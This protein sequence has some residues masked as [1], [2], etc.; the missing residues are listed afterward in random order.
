M[1]RTC[2]VEHRFCGLYNTSHP[3]PS[4]CPLNPIVMSASAF[5]LILGGAIAGA[6]VRSKLPEHHLT[7][8]SKEVIRLSTALV[9]TLTALV[10]ALMF[11]ATRAS[12]EH[13]AASI[14]RLATDISELDDVLEEYGP[15][16]VPI[17]K[18]LREEMGPLIDAMWR[19]DAIAA[20]RVAPGRAKHNSTALA[21]VR[22]LQPRT[23][24]QASL[25]ARALQIS[26]DI[27]QTRLGLFAQPPDSVSTPFM[28]VLILWMMFLFTT[29]SMSAK[30]NPT[31]AIVLFVCILSASGAIYLI[32]ELGLP[33]DGLMQVS[34]ES[35]RE[36]LAPI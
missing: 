27:Q 23:P 7:G 30:P 12:F 4:R 6:V 24:G 16:A 31:L 35:L 1:N 8:D 29:F 33:F 11:A 22:D 34:N 32:L 2:V 15:E 26:T 28:V 5:A 14:S 25:H 20:G 36:A 3:K 18:Q 9:A 10:L 17:R 13:T 21:M 19:E